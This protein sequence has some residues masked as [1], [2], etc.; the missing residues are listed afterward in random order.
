MTTQT[1]QPVEPMS[2][3]RVWFVY[4]LLAVIVGG[5]LI[6]VATQRE[7]WPFSPYQM[8]SKPSVGWEVKREMLRGVTAGP[9]PTEVSLTTAQLYPIPYQMVVVNMQ[10][11]GA[12]AT[13]AMDKRAEA[14]K[15]K[16]EGKAGWEALEAEAARK[17][18]E[19]DRIVGGLLLHYN[20]R[21]KQGKH[22]GPPLQSI[23]LYQTTWKMDTQAS[24]ASK[25]AGATVLLY[26]HLSAEEKATTQPS[27]AT[28]IVSEF[29]D[30][31]N[32]E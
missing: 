2:P 25:D 30:G 9:N 7:H 22:T 6:E 29:D 20:R 31:N 21:L 17:Q 1:V 27:V 4:A 14:A 10:H 15:L 32:G 19:A 16:A 8:W 26:P 23:R 24:Q 18:A 5:H 11:A 28:Q 3:R 13:A 12:A